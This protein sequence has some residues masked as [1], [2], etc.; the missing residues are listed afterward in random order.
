MKLQEYVKQ[1]RKQY[2]LTQVDLSEKSGVGLRFVREL[3]QGKRSLRMDKVNQVLS[4]FGSELAP[5]R[6]DKSTLEV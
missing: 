1:M 6:M 3:E 2:R 4:L 5:V